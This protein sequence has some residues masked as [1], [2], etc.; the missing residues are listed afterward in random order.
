[1]DSFVLPTKQSYTFLQDSVAYRISNNKKI[2]AYTADTRAEDFNKEMIKFLKN[3]DLL[4]MECSS[5]IKTKD[6]L[7]PE[8]A[9]EIA[10]QINPKK[11]ILTH[12]NPPVE[13]VNIKKLA[14]KHYKGPIILARDLMEIKL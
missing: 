2:L 8:I 12:F 6:H 9:G 13:K 5:V 11:L 10:S 14:G 3:I 1:M 7:S 4:I